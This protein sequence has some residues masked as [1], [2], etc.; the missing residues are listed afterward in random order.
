MLSA[1]VLAQREVGEQPPAGSPPEGLALQ[2]PDGMGPTELRGLLR[3]LDEATGI[4]APTTADGLTL[5]LG[6]APQPADVVLQPAASDRLGGLELATY[7]AQQRINAATSLD[8]DSPQVSLAERLTL[9]SPCVDLDRPAAMAYVLSAQGGA[10]AVLDSVTLAELRALT[11][12][13]RRTQ[14]P[15]RFR[16]TL[17][18]PV[19]VDLRV[20]SERLRLAN[21]DENGLVRLELP[22]GTSTIEVSVEVVTSGVFDVTFDVLTPG[23]ADLL[24]RQE[25]QVRS[26]AFSGVGVGLS[27]ASLLVLLAWWIRTARASKPDAAPMAEKG[28]RGPVA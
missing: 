6:Q 13:A 11:L 24:E 3:S 17:E 8:P 5:A 12:A 26:R 15:L 1:P 14:V 27:V 19:Q 4:L 16:N 21:A 10:E 22:P 2:V 20:R 18:D 7:R 28:G 23:G 9:V 25:A